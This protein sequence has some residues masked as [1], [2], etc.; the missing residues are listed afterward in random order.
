MGFRYKE[1]VEICSRKRGIL[2]S[3]YPATVL[4]AV[5]KNR[6]IVEY[7]TRYSDDKTRLLTAVV[8]GSEIRPSPPSIPV[9]NFAES[10]LVDAYLNGAW[11]TGR[12]ARKVDPNYYVRLDCDGTEAHCAF[13]RVRLHLEW[14]G[15]EWLRPPA[16][17]LK[18]DG[19]EAK[20]NDRPS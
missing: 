7:Q 10:D 5:G 20:P 9:S 8:D 6:Y 13:Y 11:W 17:R 2:D 14:E 18:M 3:Y 1:A 4:A 12:I 15:G 16:N 19:G